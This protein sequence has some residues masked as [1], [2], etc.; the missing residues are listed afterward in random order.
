M[1]LDTEFCLYMFGL[2]GIM[3]V[4]VIVVCLLEEI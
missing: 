1:S 3:M 2:F 4:G